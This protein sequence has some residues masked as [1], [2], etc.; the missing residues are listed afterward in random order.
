MTAAPAGA[1]TVFADADNTLWD[2]DAVFAAAQ[3]ALLDELEGMERAAA[4]TKRLDFIRSVDQELA[5]RHHG[6]LRYP[7]ELLVHAAALAL[8]GAT[9]ERAVRA[10]WRGGE[11][12]VAP[13]AAAAIERA[14]LEKL[15]A[16]PALR[17][18]VLEG[19]ERLV[20]DECLVLVVTEGS[21]ARI[22]R[23][24]ES[25]GVSRFIARIVEAPKSPR[26]YQRVHRL[27]DAPASAFMV[28][29]DR[30]R[31]TIGGERQVS[32]RC[33]SSPQVG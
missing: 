32:L 17:P 23:T 9:P 26:L 15:R 10:V 6:G 3:L 20:L 1:A 7:P 2:T 24:A 5:E 13:E 31:S 27:T 14:Y 4:P 18:G 21:L 12:P 16:L 22:R 11:R 33:L 19:L 25:L 8:R 29:D 28:G 30:R